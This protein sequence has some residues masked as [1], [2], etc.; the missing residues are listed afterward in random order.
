MTDLT[1]G[2]SVTSIGDNAFASCSS[3]TTVIIPNSVATI[4]NWA[5]EGCFALDTLVIGSGVTNFGFATLASCMQLKC[6][7][8]LAVNPPS[9][10]SNY[11]YNGFFNTISY[12]D[13]VTLHVLP[14]CLEAYQAAPSWQWFHEILGDVTVT[15]PGDVDGD[16]VVTISD[17]NSVIEVII[18]G[19]RGG[20]NHAP[21]HDD[22]MDNYDLNG[23][24][25]V[26][27][28]DLNA[29]INIIVGN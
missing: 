6:I 26:S 1:I 12:Y 25:A 27:I 8:C 13:R 21:Q 4:G 17:V 5:F 18:N 10:A 2:Q 28:S 3:L 9:V 22:E 15:I 24:G 16:G 29:I 11:E 7:I 20:H 14:S 23:D 19:G